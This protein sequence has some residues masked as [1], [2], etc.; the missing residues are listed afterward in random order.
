MFALWND[1]SAEIQLLVRFKSRRSIGADPPELTGLDLLEHVAAPEGR[2]TVVDG[3]MS[4]ID[5]RLHTPPFGPLSRAGS[6]YQSEKC[7]RGDCD[8]RLAN[9][10]HR[11]VSFSE[12]SSLP[13]QPA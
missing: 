11:I 4:A 9:L 6:R 2:A 3:D 7:G 13:S 1:C 10:G 12:A 8:Q 5:G